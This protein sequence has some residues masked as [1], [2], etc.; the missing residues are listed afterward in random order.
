M[1]YN[2][3]NDIYIYI[4]I[5]S[6]VH[7]YIHIYILIHTMPSYACLIIH[8]HTLVLILTSFLTFPTCS[9]CLLVICLRTYSGPLNS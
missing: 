5:Y 3:N 7:I 6:Y 2:R 1:K 9:A 4:Y 8:T